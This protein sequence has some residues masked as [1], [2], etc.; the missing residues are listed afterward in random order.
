MDAPPRPAAAGRVRGIYAREDEAAAFL[1]RGI[2]TFATGDACSAWIRQHCASQQPLS[3]PERPHMQQLFTT[4][5]TEA[6]LRAH[7]VDARGAYLAAPT[8]SARRDTPGNNNR[9]TA[10]RAKLV[11]EEIDARLASPLHDKRPPAAALA[12]L[13]YAWSHL[14]C[15]VYVLIRDGRVKIFAP[16]CNQDYANGWG[17]SL[18]L[19]GDLGVDAYYRRKRE[20][21]G[22]REEFVLK[23]KSAWWANGN[24]VCNEH[25][26][27]GLPAQLSQLW[28]DRF[29][30][31]LRHMLDEVCAT[32]RVGDCEFFVNKRDYP[33]LK[34]NASEPYGF[35]IDSDDRDPA[36]DATLP[37]LRRGTKLAPVLSFYTSSVFAD[38][39]LPP[40][41]DWEAAVG[42][43]FPP[44]FEHKDGAPQVKP[45]D[46]FTEA[47]FRKFERSWADKRETAFFR[48]TATG[49]GTSTETNQRLALA[50]LDCRTEGGLID[51]KLTG[52]NRRDKKVFDGPVTHVDPADFRFAAGRQNFVPIFEQS[53]YK[54][55]IYV[56]GHC[57]ACRYGF[58]M[59]LGSVILKVES[60]CVADRTWYMPLLRPWVDHV[61]VRADLSD[62]LDKVRW[63]RAHDEACKKIARE[64][65]RLWDAY[66]DRDGV[67]DYLALTLNKVS[68]SAVR[69]PAW[70]GDA[71]A[72]SR[73]PPALGAPRADCVDGA[74]C[75]R[76]ASDASAARAAA[77]PLQKSA[78]T[79]AQPRTGAGD[80]AL[81]ARRLKRRRGD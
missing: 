9:W 26:Q 22:G 17:A 4:S 78:L 21:C 60:R 53:A 1:R 66:L 8:S 65:R 80:A 32:R 56:E 27:E 77:A 48:G 47:K 68:E 51:C 38:L 35:M 25:S 57:A 41:E 52:W 23:D 14:R 20:R 43:V 50:A 15:G 67:L 18:R 13:R 44:S 29:L 73:A 5:V 37:R 24:V 10:G 39:A 69:P 36:Q 81:R 2:P 16:F 3:N 28:G 45:R 33:Q 70:L 31:P 19:E 74:P 58:M 46:L 42:E 6:Q 30:A 61:P 55:L 49:G 76:C 12:T 75:A 71:D 11:G 72:R 54:Y 64:A 7:V 63:C 59:R 62:L 40:S 34:A 79:A